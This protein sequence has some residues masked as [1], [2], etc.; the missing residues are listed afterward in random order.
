MVIFHSYVSLPEGI[1]SS[2]SSLSSNL[3]L[4][5]LGQVSNVLMMSYQSMWKQMP[6]ISIIISIY[7]YLL[8]YIYLSWLPKNGCVGCLGLEFD[9]DPSGSNQ[10]E[11]TIS[12]FISCIDPLILFENAWKRVIPGVRRGRK[13]MEVDGSEWNWEME[14]GD[15]EAIKN[16]ILTIEFS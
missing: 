16:A 6:Y 11:K 7:I 5:H 4:G 9:L 13:W 1:M 14:L 2:L 3:H 8:L 12:K 10:L 15:S